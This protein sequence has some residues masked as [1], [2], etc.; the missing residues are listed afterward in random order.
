MIVPLKK[1]P[2]KSGQYQHLFLVLSLSACAPEPCHISTGWWLPQ[3]GWMLCTPCQEEWNPYGGCHPLGPRTHLGHLWSV[4]LLHCRFLLGSPVGITR[5][6]LVPW[7]KGL[8]ALLWVCQVLTSSWLTATG[9]S[10]W[11]AWMRNQLQTASTGSKDPISTTLRWISLLVTSLP[12]PT[13]HYSELE[14]AEILLAEYWASEQTSE[15]SG[16]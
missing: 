7:H 12:F 2:K 14:R 15:G 13:L 9:S 16:L 10:P 4:C 6:L 3:W 8:F 5:C 11:A 1:L